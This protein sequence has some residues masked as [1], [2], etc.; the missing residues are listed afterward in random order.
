MLRGLLNLLGGLFLLLVVGAP[1]VD[2]APK[3]SDPWNTVAMTAADSPVGCRKLPSRL[4]WGAHVSSFGA[5]RRVLIRAQAR[6]AILLYAEEADQVVSM[7]GFTGRFGLISSN[8]KPLSAYDFEARRSRVFAPNE[9]DDEIYRVALGPAGQLAAMLN[10]NAG[11]MRVRLFQKPLDFSSSI[12]MATG[13]DPNGGQ[14]IKWCGSSL[15]LAAQ[16]GQSIVLDSRSS[17]GVG[18]GRVEVATPPHAEFAGID[19]NSRAAIVKY[20]VTDE[21]GAVADSFAPFVALP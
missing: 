3:L 18:V 6:Q 9:V 12:D 8:T 21:D 5:K 17:N 7:H 16:V 1:T 20:F 4:V 2:A 11:M 10:P 19:C 15:V 14:F 13:A